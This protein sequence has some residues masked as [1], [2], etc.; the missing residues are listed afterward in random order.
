MPLKDRDF[1]EPL[2]TI[3][4]N[5]TN[6]LEGSTAKTD[7]H[8]LASGGAPGI[9]IDRLASFKINYKNNLFIKSRV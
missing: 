7:F 1:T 2:S 9:G 5:V 3:T 4:S 6:N 8:I